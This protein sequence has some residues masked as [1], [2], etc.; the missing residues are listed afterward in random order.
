[1]IT[2]WSLR[3]RTGVQAQAYSPPSWSKCMKCDLRESVDIYFFLHLL[4]FPLVLP[5]SHC[6]H[7]PLGPTP[8]DSRPEIFSSLEIDDWSFPTLIWK[9]L[10]EARLESKLSKGIS[11]ASED[12]DFT[13]HMQSFWNVCSC[14][15]IFCCVLWVVWLLCW[16]GLRCLLLFFCF[17]SCVM[18]IVCICCP[19]LC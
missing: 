6:D 1:M 10:S 15:T 12:L 11:S 13:L 18:L 14:H 2:Q 17:L 4:T 16:I 7:L 19:F 3:L 9:W 8:G 5:L